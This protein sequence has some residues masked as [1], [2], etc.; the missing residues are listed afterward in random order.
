MAARDRRYG[1]SVPAF[2]KRLTAADDAA[3]TALW[4]AATVLRR[5]ELGLEALHEA[6]GVLQRPDAFG[7]GLFEEATAA[8]I[9]AAAL[10]PAAGLGPTAETVN[11]WRL[12]WRC[13]LG[14]TTDAASTTCQGSRTSPRW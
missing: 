7:V 10:V 2:L 4:Q 13:R 11:W 6:A 8:L 1:R 9:T 3:L 12:R 14:A 5:E